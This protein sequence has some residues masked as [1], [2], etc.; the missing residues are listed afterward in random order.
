MRKWVIAKKRLG[1]FLLSLFL[2]L[3]LLQSGDWYPTSAPGML[4]S[5]LFGFFCLSVLAKAAANFVVA[6]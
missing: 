1:G 2:P 6:I 4:V 3:C 5:V